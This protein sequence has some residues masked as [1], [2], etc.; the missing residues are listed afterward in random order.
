MDPEFLGIQSHIFYK[1]VVLN[2][3][4]FIL[5][6]SLCIFLFHPSFSI[7]SQDGPV[8]E[9]KKQIRRC[10]S[11]FYFGLNYSQMEPV[12]LFLEFHFFLSCL[13]ISFTKF[14]HLY[15]PL[16]VGFRGWVH[17]LSCEKKF[18]FFFPEGYVPSLIIKISP[19]KY[20][21]IFSCLRVAL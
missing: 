2:L 16:H 15:C 21:E 14:V 19:I 7:V 17:C 10:V 20:M 9:C 11:A 13:D 3:Y 6:T 1:F 12:L 5:K 8:A 18:R 4:R